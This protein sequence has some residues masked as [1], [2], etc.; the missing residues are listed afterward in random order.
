MNNES[1]L[2]GYFLAALLV[3]S[4]LIAVLGTVFL[5]FNKFRP[6]TKSHELLS[7]VWWA[8]VTVGVT[9]IFL[10]VFK[11]DLLK[12]RHD[13]AG[14]MD[15]YVQIFLMPMCISAVLSIFLKP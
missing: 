9:A 14:A 15:F 4:N 3:L 7:I 13:Y 5:V 8:V 11:T 12:P 10:L 1:N 6:S 2:L